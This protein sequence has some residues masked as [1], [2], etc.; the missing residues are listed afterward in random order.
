MKGA[1]C[2]QSVLAGNCWRCGLSRQTAM[3]IAAPF[4]AGVGRMRHICGALSGILM[5]AGLKYG[6]DEISK[7]EKARVYKMART[8]AKRFKDRNGSII[9]AELLGLDMSGTDIFSTDESSEPSVRDARYYAARPCAKIIAS[10]D[11]I[12]S[13]FVRSGE[14]EKKNP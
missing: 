10:A 12:I 9:C 7:E 11:E 4:G 2:A 13:D 8:I 6:S 3:K 5:V 14:F 1:S